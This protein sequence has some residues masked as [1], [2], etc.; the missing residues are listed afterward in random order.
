MCLD[1]FHYVYGD[2]AWEEETPYAGLFE[3]DMSVRNMV[4]DLRKDGRTDGR[5]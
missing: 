5:I 1:R 4:M 3:R 2:D